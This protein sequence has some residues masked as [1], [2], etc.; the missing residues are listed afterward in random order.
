MPQS[1]GLTEKQR[2]Q[3]EKILLKM[4]EELLRSLR[5]R[6]T[7]KVVPETEKEAG[8]LFDFATQGREK[9]YEYALTHRDQEKLYQIDDALRRLKKGEYGLCEECG[10]PIGFK[11]LKAMPFAR[12][13]VRCQEEE[14]EYQKVIQEREQEE[15]SRQYLEVLQEELE[16]EEGEEE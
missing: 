3:F 12:L 7:Q 9:E 14:E 13:C 11:R 2:E 10:E 16:G 15:D 4:R 8:D 1:K 6:I 5:G